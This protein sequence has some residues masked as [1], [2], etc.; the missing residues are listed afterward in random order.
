MLE[1]LL[2]YP[3]HLSLSQFVML[4]VWIGFLSFLFWIVFHLFYWRVPLL[5][6]GT[7][8]GCGVAGFLGLLHFVI[9]DGHW[10]EVTI[11]ALVLLGG[12][13]GGGLFRMNEDLRD[14]QPMNAV[15]AIDNHGEIRAIGR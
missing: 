3:T 15:I 5:N 13:I 10:N 14:R 1:N 9:W 11:I 2:I 12:C 4:L 8:L 6:P 7:L